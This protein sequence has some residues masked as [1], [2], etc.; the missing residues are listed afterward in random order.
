[1]APRI[2]AREDDEVSAT[3][4]KMLEGRGHRVPAQGRVPEA[5]NTRNGVGIHVSC[6]E[7]PREI[8]GSHVL[9]AV[10]REPNTQDLGLD[11]AA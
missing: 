5:R 1:M 2:V 8:E 11:K 10:G 7:E 3:I 6:Q 9:L 4:Q